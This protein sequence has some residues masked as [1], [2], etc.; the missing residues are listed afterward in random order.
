MF[1]GQILGGIME[2]VKVSFTKICTFLP[3]LAFV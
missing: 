1:G 3:L 2:N